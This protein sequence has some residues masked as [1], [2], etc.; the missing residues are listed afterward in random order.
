MKKNLLLIVFSIL[1]GTTGISQSFN[2]NNITWFGI[3]YTHCYFLMPMDF[4]N[5]SDLRVKLRAWNDLPLSERDK[6]FGKT[7]PGKDVK[8]VVGMIKKRNDQ[9]NVRDHITDDLYKSSHLDSKQ[10]QE[11]IS[12]YDIPGDLSFRVI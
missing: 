11:I 2:T 3:D 10:V 5:V 8:F 1:F 4:P 7:M 9:I 6:Y 12:S